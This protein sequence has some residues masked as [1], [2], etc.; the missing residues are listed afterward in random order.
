MCQYLIESNS[1]QKK[2]KNLVAA[3]AAAVKS[4]SFAA[5]VGVGDGQQV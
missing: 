5:A 4:V 2:K 1:L 3:A